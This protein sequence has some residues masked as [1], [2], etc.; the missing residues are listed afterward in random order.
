MQYYFFCY[1]T[2]CILLRIPK[3]ISDDPLDPSADEPLTCPVDQ[4]T[5]SSQPQSSDDDANSDYAESDVGDTKSAEDDETYSVTSEDASEPGDNCPRAKSNAKSMKRARDARE[6]VA[7]LE[8]K[9]TMSGQKA[10]VFKQG[11]AL[12]TQA[13]DGAVLETVANTLGPLPTT[14]ARTKKEQ[15]KMIERHLQQ[16]GDVRRKK[17]QKADLELAAKIFGYLQ[18]KP[19][20]GK[21]FVQGMISLLESYQLI[22]AAWMIR[23]EVGS[24]HP[25]GGILADEMGLGKTVTSLTCIAKNPPYPDD[26]EAYCRATLV[27]VPNRD[28]AYQWLAETRKHCDLSMASNVVIFGSEPGFFPDPNHYAQQWVV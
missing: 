1:K 7:Q 12:A 19:R 24:R 14:Y 15:F 26:I 10:R 5:E 22:A 11:G 27:V 25:D 20:D 23:R 4:K 2:L 8:A 21:W 16:G 6:Y 9:E 13:G 18:V 28:V 17:S 3:L